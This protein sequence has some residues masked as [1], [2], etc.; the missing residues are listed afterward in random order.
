[1]Q[2]LTVRKTIGHYACFLKKS[3]PSPR[4]LALLIETALPALL[5]FRKHEFKKKAC[6]TL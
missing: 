5:H 6:S 3:F 1:M 4:L 2:E